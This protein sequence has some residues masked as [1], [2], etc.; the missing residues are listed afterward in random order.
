MTLDEAIAQACAAVG[1]IE[2]RARH[3]RRWIKTDTLSGKNGHGDGRVII[4]EQ[5][6]TA[7]NWQTGDK[8]TVWLNGVPS[9]AERKAAAQRIQHDEADRRESA[10]KAADIASRLLFAAKAGCHDYLVS[11]GFPDERPLVIGADAVRGIAGKYLVPSPDAENAIVLPARIGSALRS[12]QLIWEDGVKK[13]LA[14]GQMDEATLRIAKGRDTWL[15]EGFA[16]GLTLRAAL[17]AIGRSDTILCCFSAHNL[18]KVARRI[19]GRCF[20]VADHDKPMEQFGGLGTGE[21]YA[22]QSGKPYLMP[23]A[24][25][26]DIND[27]ER[28]EGRFAVQ[29]LVSTFL[30]EAKM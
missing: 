26:D 13:F 21:H 12:V 18:T 2:P 11:K 28:K 7:W 17:R 29:R 16:T 3:A 14:G 20:I 27:L 22:R 6:V 1:L 15:C 23:A 4:D 9:P 5:R 8:E 10:R 24:A 25:G 19:D 30:R